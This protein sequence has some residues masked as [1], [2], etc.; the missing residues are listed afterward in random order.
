MFN[1]KRMVDLD[2]TLAVDFGTTNSSAYI[3]KNEKPEPLSNPDKQGK[4]LF[5]S[6]V[7]YTAK[8]VVVG[9]PAK[10]NFGRKKR[11]VVGAV[12][13]IIGQT[14]EEYGEMK[15]KTIFGCEVVRGDDGYPRFVVSNDGNT[16]SPVDVASELFKV[17]KKRADE[18]GGKSYTQAY[19]TVP[20]NFKDHQCRLIRKAAEMA[21]LRVLK[22]ITEPTAAAMS[23]CFDN[24]DKLINGEHL[25]VYDFGGGTFD[26]SHVQYTGNGKFVIIDTAGDPSLGGNDIDTAIIGYV[27]KKFM[28]SGGDEEV[29][30]RI[31]SNK[32][33]RNKLRSDC[34]SVK[35]I[36]TNAAAFDDDETTYYTTNSRVIQPVDFTS[37]NNKIYDVNVGVKDLNESI[38]PLIDKSIDITM[39]LL[40]K[41]HLMRGNI[42]HFFLVGGSS[43]LHLIKQRI[44]RQFPGADFPVYN[45]DE[46]VAMGAL[47]MLEHDNEKGD[48]EEGDVQERIV[49]SYGLQSGNDDV[50][51]LLEKGMTIPALSQTFTFRNAVGYEKEFFMTIYQWTGEPEELP[52]YGQEMRYHKV[53]VSESTRIETCKFA[54]P[55]P[56]EV[57]KQ[58]LKLNFDLKVGGTL[59]VTCIDEH[60]NEVLNSTVFEA[61]YGGH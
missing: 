7:E 37:Y 16:V 21:G 10:T 25:I 51:L 49:T 6:F 26:V 45:P 57:G 58:R 23:W 19:V 28:I 5:P 42:K 44:R 34:E 48:D 56:Q 38:K 11:F 15:D 33:F 53:K 20:A 40:E 13:R 18:F 17:I 47:K 50:V 1:K 31:I 43:H 14:Y 59:E 52:L 12:K 39:K 46:A 35:I 22:L 54:N 41:N 32:S 27:L 8:G 30:S 61:V 4:N 29:V 24:A 3:W 60:T 36:N 9:Q 2:N 55:Y